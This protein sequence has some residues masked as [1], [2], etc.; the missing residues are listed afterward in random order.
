MPDSIERTIY[1]LELDGSGYIAGVDKLSASTA[2]LSTEQEKANAELKKSEAALNASAA[3]VAKNVKAQEDFIKSKEQ[4]LVQDLKIQASLK[5]SQVEQQKLID[6]IAKN[7][8][9]YDAAASAANNFAS[10]SGRASKLQPA[11]G[12]GRIPTPA[13]PTAVP[14]IDQIGGVLNLADFTKQLQIIEQTKNE[15][16]ELGVAVALAESRMA[17]LN[18]SDDEFKQLAPIVEKG[19]EALKQYADV[20]QMASDSS[21]SLRTQIRQGKEEL[22]KLEQA[23]KGATKQYFDLEK[24]VAKLTDDFGDQQ[25][26]IKILA[27]DTKALDF[28]KGAITAA[29]SAF[30]AYTAV[31]VLVGDNNEELQ[32][33]TQQLFAA[34]QLLQSIEQLSNLTRREGVLATLAQSGAQSVY[35]V[36]V[37]ASTGALKAFKIALAST[38]ILAAVVLVGYLVSKWLELKAAQEKAAVTQKAMLDISTKAVESYGE[39]VVHIKLLS[40]EYKDLNTSASRKKAIQD[41]L[42]KS[43]PSYFKDLDKHADKEKYIADQTEK[44]TKAIILQAKIQGAQS[45]LAEKFQELLKKQF[46]PKLATDFGDKLLSSFRNLTDQGAKA[47]LANTASK[48]IK[49]AEKEYDEFSKFI[50]DFVNKS[51]AELD[52]LG[53]DPKGKVDK[54]NKIEKAKKEIENEFARKKAELDQQLAELT[55]KEADNESKIR[56]EYAARLVKEQQDIAKL[57]KDKKL[58]KPQAGILDAEAIQINAVALN[59][60]LKDFRKKQTDERQKLNDDLYALQDKNT[61]DQLNLLQSEFDRRAKLIQFMQEKDVVDTIFRN[62]KRLEDFETSS[63][64]IYGE[65]YKNN[66]VFIDQ[67]KILIAAGE[68]EITNITMDAAQ[69]RAQLSADIFQD[70]LDSYNEAISN[71]NLI[72]DE[73]QARDLKSTK[74]KYLSG[75]ISFQK[76]QADIKKIKDAHDRDMKQGE[77]VVLKDQLAAID[78]QI[79]GTKD[80]TSKGYDDLV[81]QQKEFR[82]VIADKESEIAVDDPNKRKVETLVDYVNSIAALADSV[83]GF[84][85]AAN[86]AESEA[87]DRSISLQEKRVSAAQRIADRGNAQYLKAEEDRLI[88]L[89]LKRENAARKQLGI[90]A[91][92]QASQI[93]VGITGAIAKIATPGIGIAETIGA[94]AII[95]GSLATGYGLVKSLQGNQPKL[96]KGTLRVKR[97]GHPAGTDTIP[98]WLNEGEAVIPTHRNKAYHP[99]VAAIYDGT[100]P[101][102]HLNNFV[103]NFHQVKGVPQVDYSRIK[104]AAELHIG[105]DGRMSVLLLEQNRLI[106]ENNDLQRQTLRAFKTNKTEI[107]LDANGFAVR[108]MEIIDQM[109]IDKRL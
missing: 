65:D 83:V 53:G 29:T 60:A 56:I 43:Y 7:K 64:L 45:L 61:E 62:R 8:A 81:K 98:A 21:G 76:F 3:V 101:A 73:D 15:F 46:D 20:T 11:P 55:R 25:A 39:E 74:D 106:L 19:K 54:K 107:N 99:T 4:N 23:G 90:D 18:E 51:N 63:T 84:W 78:S 100:I 57:L 66:K 37:G 86:K 109:N 102:E 68:Q 44:V 77:L 67:K 95:V 82:K 2:K 52:V 1:K 17:Q 30:Q 40:S 50:T 71:A 35:T 88:E 31:S 9:A 13:L 69:K 38:G 5:K 26:R 34:M 70:L 89:N 24:Q 79:A 80:K 32:K 27:S 58:T 92:L 104:N 49:G 41:E 6:I 93:L 97:D 94:I 16:G 28:G 12:Q 48:N 75:K 33:K 14:I 72:R 36:V 47:D 108:Q 105:H 87:I 22:V 10:I 103:R 91:A 85:Q 59:K 42:Q 96:A